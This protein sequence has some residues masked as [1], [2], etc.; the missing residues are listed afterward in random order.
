MAP[1]A[2]AKFNDNA[3]PQNAVIA[4]LVGVW[5]LLGVGYFFGQ[6][7]LYIALLLVSGFT[8]TLAWI[9]LCL[10]QISFRSRL[11]QA[12]YTIKDLRYATPSSP[13]TGIVAIILMLIA[14]FF[15]AFNEDPIYKM[16]FGIGIASFITPIIIYKLFDVSKLRHKALHLKSR[17]KFQDLFPPQ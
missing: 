1:H 3:I 9:S 7:K 10:S 2:F 11:Y 15:L 4:T 17:V 16:A 8:G 14:L 5:T 12:G 13:Y 6:T